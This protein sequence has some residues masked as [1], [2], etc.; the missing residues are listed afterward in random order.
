MSHWPEQ[1]VNIITA[2]LKDRN[3]S[4]VVA[5]FGCGKNHMILL[6]TISPIVKAFKFN[7]LFNHLYCALLQGRQCLQKVSLIKSFLLISSQMIR[8]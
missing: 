8:Q 7:N 3:P 2:W 4:L 5:D 6:L 1:P